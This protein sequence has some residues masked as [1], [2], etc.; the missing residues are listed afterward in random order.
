MSF[1]GRHSP[2]AATTAS[3][4]AAARRIRCCHRSRPRKSPGESR[5]RSNVISARSTSP[6]FQTARG[7]RRTGSPAGL[8]AGFLAGGRG[9]PP[10]DQRTALEF[11]Q[12]VYLRE[13]T[14]RDG[15]KIVAANRLTRALHRGWV[16]SPTDSAAFFH[17]IDR[18]RQPNVKCLLVCRLDD[19]A[20]LGVFIL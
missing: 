20:I 12:R 2:A 6:G 14:V 15:P 9:V 1:R 11:A 18:C 5:R 10:A 3:A 17:W 4:R 13:P 16:L 8:S 19:G 7:S